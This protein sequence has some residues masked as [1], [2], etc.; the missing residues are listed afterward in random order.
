MAKFTPGNTSAKGHGRPPGS[1]FSAQLRE[2]VGK[3]EF[4]RLVKSLLD[5]ALEGDTAA[6]GVLINRLVPAL[7]PISE[8]VRLELPEAGVGERAEAVVQAIA[9]GAVAPGDG[10]LML[11]ALTAAAALGQV[12]ELEARIAAL[13][14][15]RGQS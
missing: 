7:K 12:A 14:G 11:D 3:D 15:D 13:E 1:G 2:V 10:K 9:D 4:K 8:P 5:R 6:A